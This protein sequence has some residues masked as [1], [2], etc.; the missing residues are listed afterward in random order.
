[1]DA[2]HDSTISFLSTVSQVGVINSVV[3][4]MQICKS[5]QPTT[6]TPSSLYSDAVANTVNHSLFGREGAFQLTTASLSAKSRSI[7]G[8]RDRCRRIPLKSRASSCASDCRT[9]EIAT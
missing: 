5:N 8:K 2:G 4:S 9:I 6:T 7:G 1:M 3:H